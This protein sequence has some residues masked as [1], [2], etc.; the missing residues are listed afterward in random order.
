MPRVLIEESTGSLSD[1]LGIDKQGLQI[2][3]LSA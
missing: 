1:A 2:Y 3:G